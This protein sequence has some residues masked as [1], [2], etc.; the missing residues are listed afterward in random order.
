ML[1]FFTQPWDE[2]KRESK[3]IEEVLKDIVK[4]Y[5]IRS[6]SDIHKYLDSI[7][8]KMFGNNT[9]SWITTSCGCPR[10]RLPMIV[11]IEYLEPM[12][13]R[14]CFPFLFDLGD[15]VEAIG[16][17]MLFTDSALVLVPV[18]VAQAIS[19]G[20]IPWCLLEVRAARLATHGAL[21]TVVHVGE[22]H[23]ASQ[24]VVIT[25]GD[26]CSPTHLLVVGLLGHGLTAG[27]ADDLTTIVTRCT[28]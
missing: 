13:F 28:L 10:Q 9:R 1:I 17:D 2:T 18:V 8:D 3:D 27:A 22:A 25:V 26:D 21:R 11:S 7:L 12:V 23:T 6:D 14:K 4:N 24:A 20:P 15:L 16:H 19:V 5:V